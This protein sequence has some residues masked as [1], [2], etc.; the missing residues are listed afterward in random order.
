MNKEG[1][2]EKENG[3]MSEIK[4]GQRP[5]REWSKKP[6][7]QGP[8]VTNLM[9]GFDREVY[10][11]IDTFFPDRER[12]LRLL[13][14]DPEFT[15]YTFD[16]LDWIIEKSE[17]VL[18]HR[19]S[20]RV[21]EYAFAFEEVYK[22][23]KDKEKIR[24]GKERGWL[25]EQDSPL[26]AITSPENEKAYAERYSKMPSYHMNLWILL[27]M[28]SYLKL[29]PLEEKEK[30]WKEIDPYV[31]GVNRFT[32]V[33]A[34]IEDFQHSYI[35]GENAHSAYFHRLQNFGILKA[36]FFVNGEELVNIL[37]NLYEMSQKKVTPIIAEK[38]KRT[39]NFR[40]NTHV[41]LM[42]EPDTPIKQMIHY[43]DGCTHYE[44]LEPHSGFTNSSIQFKK[45]LDVS[46]LWHL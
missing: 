7:E 21:R 10:T 15:K 33:I 6:I 17:L 23:T 13:G 36:D 32:A 43:L 1:E 41:A 20:I 37:Y 25:I 31:T 8:R 29:F 39:K 3:S 14:L 11:N 4:Q 27:N 40:G 30:L 26:Y 38:D 2:V 16:D 45:A 42:Y 34:P 35:V 19:P 9:L 22:H 18:V 28:A 24:F 46:E 12:K 5:K 44:I